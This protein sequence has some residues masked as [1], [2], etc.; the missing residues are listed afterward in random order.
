MSIWRYSRTPA[1]W[2]MQGFN[3][4]SDRTDGLGCNAIATVHPANPEAL[5]NGHLIQHAPDLLVALW[6]ALPSLKSLCD[7]SPEALA[8]YQFALEVI[9]K[10]TGEYP[11]NL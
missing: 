11:T 4:F 10:A 8:R 7:T 2:K 6:D 3:I 9:A 5:G 1:P